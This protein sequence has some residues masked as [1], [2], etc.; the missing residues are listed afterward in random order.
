MFA[1]L[2]DIANRPPITFHCDSDHPL[3]SLRT[4]VGG[5]AIPPCTGASTC[6][7]QRHVVRLCLANLPHNWPTNGASIPQMAQVLVTYVVTLSACALQ[8]C[9]YPH[10]FPRPCWCFPNKELVFHSHNVLSWLKE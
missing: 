1:S 5:E 2:T 9:F 8:T 3:P 6:N 7:V 10:S 4:D